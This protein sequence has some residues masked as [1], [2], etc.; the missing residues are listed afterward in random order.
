MQGDLDNCT[1]PILDAMTRT[2]YLD[3]SLVERL[4]LQKFESGVPTEIKAR[5]SDTLLE[6]LDASGPV[7]YVKVSDDLRGE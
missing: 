4:V 7:V 6:A 5:A 3:D 1:K 2:L